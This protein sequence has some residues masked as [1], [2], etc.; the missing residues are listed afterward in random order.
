MSRFGEALGEDVGGLLL[1][2]LWGLVD[3]YRDLIWAC[4]V[5]SRYEDG[6]T[7]EACLK[8]A[9]TIADGLLINFANTKNLLLYESVEGKGGGESVETEDPGLIRKSILNMCQRTGL[10]VAILPKCGDDEKDAGYD[11]RMNELLQLFGSRAHYIL[12]LQPI[13]RVTC[14]EKYTKQ[15]LTQ[16]LQK[17]RKDLKFDRPIAIAKPGYRE[18]ILPADPLNAIKW[19]CIYPAHSCIVPHAEWRANT[20]HIHLDDFLIGVPRAKRP[21]QLEYEA[22]LLINEAE[23]GVGVAE[24]K[25]RYRFYAAENLSL[26]GDISVAQRREVHERAFEIYKTIATN[27]IAYHPTSWRGNQY[28]YVCNLRQI[29]FIN[30]KRVAVNRPI[31]HMLRCAILAKA[32]DPQRYETLLELL[33][34]ATEFKEEKEGYQLRDILYFAAQQF[35]WNFPADPE[36]AC[37]EFAD[38]PRSDMQHTLFGDSSVTKFKLLWFLVGMS[39]SLNFAYA[40]ANTLL[41]NILADAAWTQNRFDLHHFTTATRTLF[42]RCFAPNTT[43]PKHLTQAQ[44]ILDTPTPQTP[45]AN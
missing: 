12:E 33:N 34:G 16:S 6:K 31:S 17:I 22:N 7:L 36:T 23:G 8:G 43:P 37:L 13:E 39:P 29:Q 35:K 5:T 28:K 41:K 14:L 44:L 26:L 24:Q 10:P 45:T 9:T 30:K 40:A 25:N 4:I 21:L 38:P 1:V 19:K 18:S 42:L 2:P 27:E 32:C 11:V 3:E 20:V 15:A